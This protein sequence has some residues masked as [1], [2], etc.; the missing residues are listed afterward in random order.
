MAYAFSF[1]IPDAGSSILLVED[2][3]GWALPRAMSDE[4]EIV[5][6]V[7]PALR[8]LVGEDV[9]V[10][11]EVRFGPIPPPEDSVVYLTEP[12][13]DPHAA[14]GWWCTQDDLPSLALGDPRDRS[15]LEAWF[16]GEPPASLQPWQRDGWFATAL[17]WLDDVLP[18]VSEVRQYATWCNSSVL[19][20]TSPGG[21]SWFKAVPTYWAHEPA[22]M[23]KLADLLPGRTP[24]VLAVDAERGW[25][26]LEDLGDEAADAL[27]VQERAGVLNAIGELHRASMPLI[28]ELLDGGCPDRRPAVLSDQIASLAD[29]AI[30]PLPGDLG[31]RLRAAVPRLQELCVELASGAIPPT[32]VHGDLH[33]GNVMRIGDRFV[34]FDWSDACIADPFVDVLMF[35]TRLPD[36]PGLRASF[37]ERYLD[38]W[39]GV[40]HSEAAAYAELA[41]PLAAMHHAI[42]YRGIYDAFGPYEWWIF[43]GALPRWIEHALA[44]RVL[45]G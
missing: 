12:V 25:M 39:P 13:R 14:R 8:D 31:M 16:R 34:V 41:E 10:L 15:A 3:S 2:G 20:V 29:D 5:V 38:A 7:A 1:L 17:D 21:R 26:L 27:P 9:V 42:T 44:C 6:R 19:R 33:A 4:P 28:E 32:L 18:G 11:R 22:V 35:L 24:K 43:E 40:T 37:R 23:V 30:V 45:A 36:D